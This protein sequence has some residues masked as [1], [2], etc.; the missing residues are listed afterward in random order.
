MMNVPYYHY[1]IFL[2]IIVI[3]GYSSDSLVD[4]K[5]QVFDVPTI[6]PLNILQYQKYINMIV[7]EASPH[8]CLLLPGNGIFCYRKN[9]PEIYNFLGYRYQEG[10]Y[11]GFIFSNRECINNMVRRIHPV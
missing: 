3:M 10:K 7:I 9:R 6:Y 2:P 1:Y 4:I 8:L 5:N 11:V